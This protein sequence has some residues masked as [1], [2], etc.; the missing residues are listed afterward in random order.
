[1]AISIPEIPGYS[2]IEEL[3][4]SR[5]TLVLRAIR[6]QTGVL[7]I[8][9]I[10]KSEAAEKE[11]VIRFRHEYETISRLN[12]PGIVKTFALEEY[13]DSLMMVMEDI[14]GKSLDRFQLPLPIINFVEIAIALA[15]AIGSIHKL[16][17]IHK[18]I[19]PSNIVWNSM[20]MHL[21]IIDFDVADEIPER[22]MSPQAPSTIEGTLEYIS[23]EQTGRMNRIVDYRT[24]FYSLGITFYQL[25]TGVLP[26]AASDPLGIVHFHIA[27]IPVAPHD[28]KF[29]I[30]AIVSNIV[31][32]LIAKMADDRYQSAWGLKADLEKCLQEL[33]SEGIIH[34]FE[35]G[36]EDFSNQLRVPQKLYGRENELA[37]L[38]QAFARVSTGKCELFLVAGYSGIGKTSLV[39]EIHRHITERKGN[40]IEGKFDQLQRDLPY[41]GWIQAFSWIV[42]YMLMESEEQLAQWKNII[43]ASVGHVGKVLTDVITNLALIIGPQSDVP[44]LRPAEA[45]NRFNYV[46]LEFIKALATSEHPLVLFLDDMHWIDAASLNLLQTL[47]GKADSSNILIIGAYRDNEV[48]DLHPLMIT[49]KALRKEQA[50]IELL[51]LGNLS[52]LIVNE[53]IADILHRDR[54]ETTHLTSLLCSKTEGNPFFLLQT[55]RNLAD[56]KA[57]SFDIQHRHWKWDIDALQAMEITDNVVALMV[58]KIQMLPFDAQHVLPLAA[59]IGFRFGLSDL[60]VIAEKSEDAVLTSLHTALAEGLI[61]PL[62]GVYQFVHD[63]VQQ[64][65]YSLIPDDEKESI[66]LTIGKHLL[67]NIMGD[68]FDEKIFQ[69]VT[70]LNQGLD[71]IQSEKDKLE[72]AELNLKAGI[73]AKQSNAYSISSQYLETG[74]KLLSIDKWSK[75]YQLAF[76]LYKHKTQANFLSGMFNQAE[77]DFKIVL[78]NAAGKYDKADIY[79]IMMIQYA[80]LGEYKKCYDTGIEGLKLFDYSLPDISTIDNVE[81]AI[82]ASVKTFKELLGNRQL[83]QIID[84]PDITN[85]DKSYVIRI[86]SSIS[87]AAYIGKPPVFPHVIFGIVNISIE[88][89]FNDFSSVGFCWL[90]VLLG[91]ILKD[92]KM[93]YDAGQLSLALN[94]RYNN[95]QLKSFTIFLTAVFTIHWKFHAKEALKYY[96][97]AFKAGVEN[98][99][100]TYSGYARVMIPKT[101]LDI[102]SPIDLARGENKRSIGFLSKNNSIFIEEEQFFREFL[103]NLTNTKEQKTNF[104]CLEFTEEEYL[105]KW[106][107]VTFGHG[108]GYYLSYKSQNLFLFEKFEEA[109]EIGVKYQDWTQFIATLYEETVFYFYHTLCATQIY[110]KCDREKKKQVWATIKEN[111]KKYS[112]WAVVCPD[113]FK[114]KH[115]LLQAEIARLEG[116]MQDAVSLYNKAIESAKEFKYVNNAAVINELAARFWLSEGY[117]DYAR[118]HLARSYQGYV[119]WKAWA[120]VKAMENRYPQWLGPKVS[121]YPPSKTSMSGTDERILD[122]ATVMKATHAISSEIEMDRLLGKIM[123]IV[124]ENA[125]AQYG[126]LLIENNDIWTVA[127]KGGVNHEEVEIHLPVKIDESDLVSLGVIRFVART[128]KKV[129]L[130]NAALQGEYVNDSHIKNKQNKSLLCVPIFHRRKMISIL[131][132][133]NNLTTHAFTPG[134]VQ[135]LELLLS[136]VAVSLE[137]AQIYEALR[138]SEQKFHA[139]F[140]QTFQFIGLLSMD[141][142]VLAV[143]HS[144][145]KFK[146][147]KEDAVLGKPF[148]DTPWWTH[149]PEMQHRLHAAVQEAANGNLVRFEATHSTLDGSVHYIDFSIKPIMDSSGRVVQL[150]PEGRDIT[151]RKQAEEELRKHR[152]HLEEMIR[153]R[154]AELTIAKEQAESASKAKSTFLSNMSHELRTPLNAILGFARLLKEAPDATPEQKKNLDIITL[155][156]GH[157]LNLINNVLDMSK[158][159][160]GRMNLD[161]TPLDLYQLLQEMRSLLYVN[162]EERGLSFIVEQSPQLPRR[163]DVDGGKLRQTLINLIGNAIKYTKRGG[164]VLR[165]KVAEK[166]TEHVR[167]RFEIE[168]TGPGISEEDRKRLFEPFVQLKERGAVVTGTGLG[169]SI[170]RQYVELMG[171]RI[172]VIS[173]KGKGSLF[174]FEI[175]VKELPL[176]E[177][178]VEPEHGRA[179][180]LEKGQ[181]RYRL[182]I[183]EDQLENR[184]LLHK[185]LQSF[186]FDIREAVNGKE[187]VELFEQWHP[188]L[189]WMDIRMP[190]MGGLEATHRIRS[191]ESG[192]HTKIIAITAQALEEDRIKIMHAGCDDFIRKPYRDTEIFDALTRHLGL[193]FAYEEKPPAAVAKEPE[194]E[195]KPEMLVELPPELLREFH[196]ALLVLD[197]EYIQMVIQKIGQY[198][199]PLGK[200]LKKHADKFGYGYLLKLLDACNREIR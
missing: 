86:L 124:I 138:A 16:H 142:T 74:I 117:E 167:L 161:L 77:K 61:T 150:L 109:Y 100:N 137:N 144:A 191:T 192:L 67:K 174:F 147:I 24:D 65:A 53:L 70:H 1:M 182:L 99:E 153:E 18:N 173:E 197:P 72:L 44:A 51:I 149:S 35:L 83:S 102:G 154:T 166:K 43:L 152:D 73:K 40:F 140:E 33:K 49:I 111:E 163:I 112:T 8:L 90:P 87:D 19:N 11:K 121:E 64:A 151:E 189:I 110:T 134:R 92:Y 56:K 126:Y 156:G 122:L 59:C 10:L 114:H 113:N 15:D 135:F 13:R 185:I 199:S 181:P 27:G 186:E 180:G 23:P 93:G 145:L 81:Q 17:T 128:G 30:P 158:I 60:G 188:D 136:Q 36:K 115:L 45:Q 133:E 2:I 183:V 118:L 143:N 52:E 165:A 68:K 184:L 168:D 95:A 94:E 21:N 14:G 146:G 57:I 46:F 28:R 62:N 34:P 63:R 125:G 9:K 55:L 58:N 107:E 132:L 4:E 80:Q 101:T 179:I 130:D 131:Y 164:I 157:L 98:G 5:S 82:N 71:L 175:P 104:D 198:N 42:N 129:V 79:L 48:D 29:D 139:I 169:L 103:N 85:K 37:R 178:E 20:S 88:Y 3:H 155:S 6:L 193:R 75:H 97:N 194:I 160:S 200:D 196:Q 25:L 31:M 89:G 26:F 148:W 171:G 39:H 105:K 119:Q 170:S 190:V 47:V 69:I 106:Q 116:R 176:E 159:E 187:A 41:F 38:L 50:K 54:R 123:H 108:L 66:H 78:N 141:G 32:K 96:D 12:R 177:A 84:L 22:T 195:L 162:A 127:A 76:E 91:M 120:K 172:D 7:V